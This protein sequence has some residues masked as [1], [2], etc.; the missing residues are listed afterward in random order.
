MVVDNDGP[1]G[2]TEVASI[3]T[4]CGAR[5]VHLPSGGNVGYGAGLA[6]GMRFLQAELD[7]EYYWTLDDDSPPSVTA[8]PSALAVFERWSPDLGVVADRGG[9]LRFGSIRHDLH[10]VA[11]PERADHA[12]VDGAVIIRAAV[13]RVGVPREDFFMTVDDFEY[14]DRIRRAG[15]ELVVRPSDSQHGYLGAAGRWRHYYQARNLLR[16]AII[17]RSPLLGL[18][19]AVREAKINLVHLARGTTEITRLRSRGALDALRGRM[20]QVVQPEGDAS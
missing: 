15:F 2:S 5:V 7:P 20:G 3:V 4:G 6:V 17:R 10:E 1:I 9:R 19:W 11:S 14:T 12:L 16:V 18:G 13:D 8:L